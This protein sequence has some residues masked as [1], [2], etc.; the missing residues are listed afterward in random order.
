MCVELAIFYFTGVK[1]GNSHI[2]RPINLPF[3]L[4]NLYLK[5][6]ITYPLT[7]IFLHQI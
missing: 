3:F 5:Q 1:V 6:G 2:I 7:L 4:T